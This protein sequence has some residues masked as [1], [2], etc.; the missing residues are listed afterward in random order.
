[1][2]EA[3]DMDPIQVWFSSEDGRTYRL[4]RQPDIR[5]M[6]VAEVAP[7]PG[8]TTNVVHV[9]PEVSYQS[10]L[11]MGSSLEEASVY[12]LLRMSPQT[13]RRVLRDLVDPDEGIGWNLFRICF[14]TSDFTSRPYYS[15]DDMP[16]GQTDM[17]LAH[18][19]IQPDIDCGIID[20]IHEVLALN[21][22]VLI[23]ASPWS[24]PGWMKSAGSLCAGG[25]LPEC[26]AVSAR[27]YRMAIEAYQAQGIPIYAFTPQN[28]P[29]MVHPGYPTCYIDWQEEQELLRHLRQ[30]FDQHG[31]RTQ[32]WIFDHNF[33]D[34]KHYP[35]RILQDPASY[36]ATDGVAL[37]DYEGSPSQMGALHDAFPQKDAFLTEHSNFRARGVDRILQYFRNWAR[38]YNAW[39]TCLDDRQQPNPGP[40]PCSPTFVTVNRDDPDDCRYIAE[41]YLFGQVSKFVR[42]GARRIASDYGSPHAVTNAAFV[43]PDGT[44]VLV[45]V[46]QTDGQQ[47]IA[48]RLPGWQFSGE[49]PAKTVATYRW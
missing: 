32:I 7:P 23:F 17:E 16:P 43:N 44:M 30:E 14:G 2:K 48:V 28:E 1:M 36:A 46:N 4:D 38:S 37:H 8:R 3:L 49:I 22:E 39:V 47:R 45:A 25:L 18:F 40:H 20:L 27:Y 41:Y 35:G 34:A 9:D 19:S 11:G 24:P 5:A 26:A 21:P 15:Y 42:R 13:R 12:H 31:I 33:K 6:P 10:I 29:L